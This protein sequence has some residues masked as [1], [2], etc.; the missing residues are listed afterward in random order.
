MD[1]DGGAAAGTEM[2]EAAGGGTEVSSNSSSGSGSGCR[3][4]NGEQL[5]R[6]GVRFRRGCGRGLGLRNRGRLRGGGGLRGRCIGL[7]EVE[8]CERLCLRCLGLFDRRVGLR[9]T[10]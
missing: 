2:G 9:L 1:D 6:R 10:A 7:D 4:R 8:R 5:D 3:G